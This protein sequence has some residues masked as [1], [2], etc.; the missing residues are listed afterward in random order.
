LLGLA[1]LHAVA[2]HP[3]AGASWEGFVIESLL[4]AAPEGTTASFF[5]TAA[6]AEID[7]L[8]ELRAD[9]GLWA[10]EIKRGLAVRPGR[11]FHLARADVQPERSFLVYAGEDR[12]PVSKDVE[13][14]GVHELAALLAEMA[15]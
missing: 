2:G 11:G 10:I 12:F 6:G 7:L 4:A 5:R 1:D 9:H 15:P 3:V 13:V 8:L 14:I